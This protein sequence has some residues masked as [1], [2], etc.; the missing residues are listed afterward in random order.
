M[1]LPL[2]VGIGVTNGIHILNRFGEERR[3]SILATS[4]GKAVVVSALTTVA[5][6]GSL[7]LAEHQGIESLGWLMS[8]GT[9]ACMVAALTCVPA[10]LNLARRAPDNGKE[11][12]Q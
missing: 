7:I 9:T 3:P 6:F 11:K 5:G 8:L 2:V 4:T 1:T 12:T 10:I